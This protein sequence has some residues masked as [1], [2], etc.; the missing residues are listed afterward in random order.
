[1]KKMFFAALAAGCLLAATT[2]SA[3]QRPARSRQPMTAEQMAKHRTERMTEALKLDEVQKQ[4]VYKLNLE[5]AQQM[6]RMREQHK[7]AAAEKREAAREQMQ[8]QA[9]DYDAKLKKL[10]SA[11]QYKQWS[12]RQQQHRGRGPAMRSGDDRRGG[13]APNAD[14]RPRRTRG[15]R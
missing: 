9:A 2:T 4:E 5:Q 14:N 13:D 1:M 7:E 12:E 3:Q 10:L 11:E 15:R 8:K 6:S